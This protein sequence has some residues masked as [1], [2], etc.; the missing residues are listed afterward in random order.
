MATNI[1]YTFILYFRGGTYIESINATDVLHATHIWAD[2][3]AL[4]GQVE[5][6]D[7]QA[8]LKVFN[9]D[10]EVFQPNEIDTCPNVWHLFFLLGRHKMD[11]HIVKTSAEPEPSARASRTT[12]AGA[13]R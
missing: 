10:I 5:H 11:I 8:F 7:G 6:L 4:A 1:T 2:R 13:A 3:I 9:N 12:D